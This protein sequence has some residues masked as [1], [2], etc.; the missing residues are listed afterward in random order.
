MRGQ[1]KVNFPHEEMWQW[2]DMLCKERHRC[3]VRSPMA[4][5]LTG[6]RHLQRWVTVFKAMTKTTVRIEMGGE[7]SRN[8]S[9][10]NAVRDEWRAEL[11]KQAAA[12]QPLKVAVTA[13]ALSA[14]TRRND[15]SA[16]GPGKL[17]FVRKH[18]ASCGV[19]AR[20][21]RLRCLEAV[22]Q[23][24]GLRHCGS[25]SLCPRLPLQT[26][27]LLFCAPKH[28][29]WCQQTFLSGTRS[30]RGA[31]TEWG[32]S[33]AL[34]IK[35]HPEAKLRFYC[36]DASKHVRPPPPNILRCDLLTFF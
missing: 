15:A 28:Q 32:V 16:R 13:S 4:C 24:V 19:P 9:V 11:R 21:R 2:S 25:S 33:G 31:L 10:R 12:A 29:I 36:V 27:Q 1:K 26:H 34:G 3:S 17:L 30:L 5:F 35:P 20:P 23:E 14:F 7:T 8:D 22:H 18:C 6:L